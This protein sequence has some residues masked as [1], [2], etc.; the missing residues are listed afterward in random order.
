MIKL[1][2]IMKQHLLIAIIPTLILALYL[3]SKKYSIVNQVKTRNIEKNIC[4]Y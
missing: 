2:Y 4:R 3:S 1:F